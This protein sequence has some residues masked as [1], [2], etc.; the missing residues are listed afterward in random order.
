MI[1]G[2]MER[3]ELY[4]FDDVAHVLREWGTTEVRS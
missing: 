3:G 2:V 4:I 1:I